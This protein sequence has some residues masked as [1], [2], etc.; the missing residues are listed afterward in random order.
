LLLPATSLI[1]SGAALVRLTPRSSKG[2]D[3]TPLTLRAF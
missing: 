1:S 3:G 2:I